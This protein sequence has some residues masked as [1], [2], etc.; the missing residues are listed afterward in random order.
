[1][2]YSQWCRQ[3]EEQ[4]GGE[5]QPLS[6]WT[7]QA[8]AQQSQPPPAHPAKLEGQHGSAYDSNSS[9]EMKEG[10]DSYGPDLLLTSHATPA[11]HAHT[12]SP[13]NFAAPTSGHAHQDMQQTSTAHTADPKPSL[14]GH[15]SPEQGPADANKGEKKKAGVRFAACSEASSGEGGCRASLH[16]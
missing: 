2:S 4:P 1:V 13:Q 10:E 16:H 8:G 5:A 3:S 11:T 14:A 12:A 6:S 9:M 7:Q 15:S